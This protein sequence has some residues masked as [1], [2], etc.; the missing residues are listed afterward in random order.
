MIYSKF[1]ENKTDMKNQNETTSK[2][3]KEL[4]P[5]MKVYLLVA[6]GTSNLKTTIGF[7]ADS[8]ETFTFGF[9]S[10]EK[11]QAFVRAQKRGGMLG[12]IGDEV[13]IYWM[14]LEEY[15]ADPKNKEL[16]IDP[17]DDFS[18]DLGAPNSN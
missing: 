10:P 8:G 3:G 5:Q 9:S 11:V 6:P 14:T 16:Y 1:R 4:D 17:P 13:V 12:N 18:V 7:T 15:F 2:S